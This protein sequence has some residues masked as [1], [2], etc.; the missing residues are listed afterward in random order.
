MLETITIGQYLKHHLSL[1][2]L[3]VRSPGEY[4]K[5][6][7]PDAVNVPIF[8]DEERADVGTT[9]KQDSKERAIEL[10]MKYVQ[11]QAEIFH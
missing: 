10:G 2:L 8:S 1:P 6:H 9:Y 4:K 11:P 3:D 7:V 5:G